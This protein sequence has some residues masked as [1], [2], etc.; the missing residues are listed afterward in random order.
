MALKHRLESEVFKQIL[1]A[2]SL[3]QGD[4]AKSLDVNQKTFSRWVN[5]GFPAARIMD[6]RKVL[7]LKKDEF[8]SLLKAPKYKLF[9]RNKYH[10]EVPEPSIQLALSWAKFL[11]NATPLATK[12]PLTEIDLSISKDPIHVAST[13]RSVLKIPIGA[14]L[15]EFVA[16][17]SRNGIEVACVPFKEMG[18]QE[19][20]E[21]AFSISNGENRAVIF[22]NAECNQPLMV[23]N[24]C[25]ELSHLARL[26]ANQGSEE[27]RFC[28]DVAAEMM[29]PKAFF[30]SKNEGIKALI[31][32]GKGRELLD[33]L[34]DQL[35]GSPLGVAIRLDSLGYLDA[36]NKRLLGHGRVL[37]SQFPNVA[38][39]L[40]SDLYSNHNTKKYRQF[41]DGLNRSDPVH[42][43]F[44]KV[45]DAVSES[46]M[47]PRRFAE[48]FGLDN[49]TA[50]S[51]AES[52]RIA[53]H[54]ASL[55]AE[56]SDH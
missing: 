49:T 46:R 50:V 42:R 7:G 37:D 31:N 47:T 10:K 34:R 2:R 3:G 26:N 32:S 53:M 23:F 27:E 11:L 6:L 43:F 19:S 52:W 20:K 56:N 44:V 12:C 45:K 13:I 24:L 41:W 25:H 1:T 9:F 54:E 4:L 33:E 16:I 18:L 51:L 48:L 36:N 22:L 39:V 21:Q 40:F 15:D 29:Y 5:E 14:G 8:D 28:Q 35:N 17:L 55:N 38:K 30:D